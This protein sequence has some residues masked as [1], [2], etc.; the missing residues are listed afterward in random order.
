MKHL[1]P[2]QETQAVLDILVEQLGVAQG[3]LT[4]EARI[5]ADLGADSL[6]VIEI[7]MAVEERLQLAIPDEQWESVS[8]V[9]DLFELLARLLAARDQSC[10]GVVEK[11][12]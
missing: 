6:T 5:Q 11:P 4:P 7:A 8:T 3:Q 10:A 12:I 1:L 9:G 2:D